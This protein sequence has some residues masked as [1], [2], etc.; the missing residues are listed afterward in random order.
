MLPKGYLNKIML[1]KDVTKRIIKQDHAKHRF[2]PTEYLNKI[3][4]SKDFTNSIIKQDLDKQG[5]YQQDN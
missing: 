2:Y 5:F 4:L 1:S 3:L